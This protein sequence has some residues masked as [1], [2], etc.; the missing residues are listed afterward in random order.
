[1]NQ[2]HLGTR[3]TPLFKEYTKNEQHSQKVNI[4]LYHW[5]IVDKYSSTWDKR[6]DILPQ[7]LMDQSVKAVQ[8]NQSYST[9]SNKVD[10]SI[11]NKFSLQLE[12]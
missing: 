3:L 5:S 2:R 9:K 1:M 4:D 7:I 12:K 11:M 10:Q 6:G 8:L